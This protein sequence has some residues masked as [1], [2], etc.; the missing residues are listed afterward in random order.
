MAPLLKHVEE[1]KLVSL[2]TRLE[3][4]STVS[5]DFLLLLS[6]SSL[7]ATIGLFQNS[8]AVIIGAMIIAPLMRPILGLSLATLTAD[9]K[10][11]SRSLIT[12]SIGTTAAISLSMLL[13]MIF[14][15][16]ELTPEILARTNPNLLDL[17]VAIFAGA[18]GAYCQTKEK[19]ADSLAGVAI[20]VALVPPLGVVGIG[21]AFG[22]FAVWTGALLLYAT[23]LVGI[24]VAGSLV[25]LF[26]GFTPLKQAKRGLLISA[27]VS[28]VLIVP[29]GYSMSEL[30]LE[31]LISSKVKKLL[32]E[33]TFTFR[34]LQLQEV[35]VKRFRKPALVIATV[36]APGEPVSSRQVAL[37]QAFLSREIGKKIEFRLR[38]IPTSEITAVEVAPVTEQVQ[39][40]PATEPSVKLYTAPPTLNSDVGATRL[41]TQ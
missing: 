37:V 29:L 36:T 9:T 7:I 18:V 14:H 3:E 25:F 23:N 35:Q 20:A 5:A 26:L 22:N 8:P 27:A 1:A 6:A 41:E 31:N 16:L 10:L 24:A 11:L 15:S 32:K 30:V 17:A 33:K 12:L 38:V 4:M 21:L 39:A 2:Q 13:A 34:G 40:L 28:L 19:L